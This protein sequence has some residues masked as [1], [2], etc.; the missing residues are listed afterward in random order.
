MDHRISR[1]L[2]IEIDDIYA[3]PGRCAGC[4]LSAN[5]RLTSKADMTHTTRQGIIAALAAY[6]PTVAGLE[7]VNIT[8]GIADH[9]MMPDD[10]LAA[11]VSE[12]FDLLDQ[13]GLADRGRV[14]LTTSLIGRQTHIRERLARL[15]DLCARGAVSP[16][17]VLDPAK[18][19]A[20]RF[21]PVYAANI[22][23][24]RN[25]FDRV[26]LAINL[27]DNAVRQITPEKLHD[28][29]LRH[30]FDEVT[31]NWTPTLDNLSATA[32]DMG[33]LAHWL[34]DF[35]AISM[36]QGRV[37]T[38]YVPVLLRALDSIECRR[39]DEGH[40]A[41]HEIVAAQLE[42]IVT[43][44]IQFDHQGNLFPKMEAIGDVAHSDR[45]GYVPLGNVAVAPIAQ[46]LQQGLP[47]VQQRI[48]AA[49][50]RHPA[51]MSCR[52]LS[53]CAV[54]G[55]HVY[56]HVLSQARRP[57]TKTQCPHVG[58]MMFDYLAEHADVD[59]RGAA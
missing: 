21:G 18:L 33:F 40:P 50:S 47:A 36:A 59:K 37:Q 51:C 23:E 26:D 38:S 19:Y 25:R 46:L 43:R 17:V 45:F 41:L 49:H 13:T 31:I 52:H 28:F 44:S 30:D 27:S 1:E 22:L 15:A 56:N 53:V 35:A 2:Q 14:F 54:T 32:S 20:E 5:E 42:Q 10:Y 9:F 39:P 7:R 11:V 16:I 24:A 58:R 34:T 4:A 48:L 55:F 29:A 57:A 12:A 6:I 3:C 8:Y